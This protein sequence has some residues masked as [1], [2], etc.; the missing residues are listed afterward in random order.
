MISCS[1]VNICDFDISFPF[2]RRH[3][4]RKDQKMSMSKKEL[5]G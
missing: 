3:W 1:G 4:M 2:Q 5:L